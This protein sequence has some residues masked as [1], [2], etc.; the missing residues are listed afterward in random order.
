MLQAFTAVT[1]VSA[2]MLTAVVSERGEKSLGVLE[3]TPESIVIADPGGAIVLINARTERL[4]G[5]S[6]NELLGQPLEVLLPE[7]FREDHAEHRATCLANTHTTPMGTTAELCARRKDGTEF[8]V[9]ITLS[10][11]EAEEDMLISGTFRDIT[12]RKETEKRLWHSERLAA[13]GDMITGLA[14]ES[15]NALQRGQACLEMLRLE[16]KDRPKA[17][18]LIARLQAAQDDLHQLYERVRVYSSPITLNCRHCDLQVILQAT[19][20]KLAQSH[21]QATFQSVPA[22]VDLQCWVD[23][24]L[25]ETALRSILENALQACGESAKITAHWTSSKIGDHPALR[26]TLSDNGPGLTAEQRSRIF[27][28]F[29]TTKTKGAGLGMPIA[30]RYVEAQAGQIS[31]G[32]CTQGTEIHV[33]LP[34][35]RMSVDLLP[36]GVTMSGVT[37]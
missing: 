22:A 37:M 32:D 30:K 3:S 14:H 34:R 15:R 18:D 12:I 7:R 20:N 13:I 8:P 31:V 9:E 6:R 28:P 16:V 5:Y 33:T 23:P 24:I 1:S 29:F 11:L 2:L 4:F 26:L 10:P 21:G 36:P 17:Q 35:G 19:W 25:V 27:Q